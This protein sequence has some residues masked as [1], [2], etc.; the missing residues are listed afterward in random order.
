MSPTI[1]KQIVIQ[2][3]HKD[4]KQIYLQTAPNNQIV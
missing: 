2:K 1:V 3:V 4:L